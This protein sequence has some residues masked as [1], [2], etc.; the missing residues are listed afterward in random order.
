[1]SQIHLNTTKSKPNDQNQID[2]NPFY[3]IL[4]P[5]NG[6]PNV[7]HDS[8]ADMVSYAFAETEELYTLKLNS[9]YTFLISANSFHA[10][11]LVN[12][13]ATFLYRSYSYDFKSIIYGN[14]LAFSNYDYDLIPFTLLQQIDSLISL[15]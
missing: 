14:V 12:N 15:L 6:Y 3:S 2:Q 7:L 11:S 13:L 9:Q 10:Y 1:M 8:M 4:I 5:Y